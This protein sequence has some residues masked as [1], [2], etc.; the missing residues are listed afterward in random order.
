M[1]CNTMKTKNATLRTVGFTLIEL[2]VVIAIIGILAALLFPAFQ[3]ARRKSEFRQMS[4]Q[5]LAGSQS[6][7]DVYYRPQ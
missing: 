1:Y 2:L 5:P 3:A 6:H 4:E 7:G